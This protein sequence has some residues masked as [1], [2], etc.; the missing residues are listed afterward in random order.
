MVIM[1]VSLL[2]PLTIEH[3]TRLKMLVREM[4][5]SLLPERHLSRAL[6]TIND[7][8]IQYR[9]ETLPGELIRNRRHTH[10]HTH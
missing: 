10:T 3:S 2:Q 6:Y 1:V 8:I 7:V 5:V 9:M 4:G